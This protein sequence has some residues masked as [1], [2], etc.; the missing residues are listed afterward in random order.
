MNALFAHTSFMAKAKVMNFQ[1]C[2]DCPNVLIK[3][4]AQY[5]YQWLPLWA[6]DCF[7]PKLNY[8]EIVTLL[9]FVTCNLEIVS[10]LNW[11]PMFLFHGRHERE[12][13]SPV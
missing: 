13:P 9:A 3:S 11:M 5:M 12:C 6:V 10:H 8:V 4:A 7:G 1:N 2:L